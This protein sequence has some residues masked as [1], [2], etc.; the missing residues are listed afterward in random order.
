MPTP[1]VSC[2]RLVEHRANRLAL[3]VANATVEVYDGAAW[4]QGADLIVTRWI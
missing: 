3:R 1:N 4:V 2:Q